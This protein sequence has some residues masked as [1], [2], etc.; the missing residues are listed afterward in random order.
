MPF[1]DDGI[2]I[3][4]RPLGENDAVV[5]IFTAQHGKHNGLVFGASGRKNVATVQIGNMVRCTWK[6]RVAQSLGFW[7]LET[8]DRYRLDMKNAPVIS[9]ACDLL[10]HVLAER[11]A[12]PEIY[13]RAVELFATLSRE[14]YLAFENFCLSGLGYGPAPTQPAELR[15]FL[16]AH[17]IRINL[18]LRDLLA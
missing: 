16:S 5:T 10:N 18:P 8:A 12:S 11:Q 9:C 13:A 1:T 2:I 6:A 3:A 4:K 7:K 15:R 17:G 14:N